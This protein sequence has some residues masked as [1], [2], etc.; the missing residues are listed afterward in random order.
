MVTFSMFGIPIE[1]QLLSFPLSIVCVFFISLIWAFIFGKKPKAAT[2][3]KASVLALI[4][5]RFSIV[6]HEAAHAVMHIIVGDAITKITFGGSVS[7][8]TLSNPI[9]T[10]CMSF[11]QWVAI[12][13]GPAATLIACIIFAYISKF[14]VK[15]SAFDLGLKTASV[16]CFILLLMNSMPGQGLDGAGIFIYLY[17]NILIG[18]PMRDAAYIYIAFNLLFIIL[19]G[20]SLIKSFVVM[21]VVENVMK[22][23]D[24]FET[25]LKAQKK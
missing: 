8:V 7:S 23:Q 20:T 10:C 16:L 11:G 6:F 19:L 24:L 17:H 12:A 14:A 21:P 15:G 25:A 9:Y 13:A 2:L 1:I 3:I 18:I 5:E 4:L 22:M